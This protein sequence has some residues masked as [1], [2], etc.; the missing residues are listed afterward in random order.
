MRYFW[1]TDDCPTGECHGR[2]AVGGLSEVGR[3]KS[4]EEDD[5]GGNDLKDGG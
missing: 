2:E 5:D 1:P 4:D 3:K